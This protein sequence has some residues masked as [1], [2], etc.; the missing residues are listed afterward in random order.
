MA[1]VMAWRYKS[2]GTVADDSCEGLAQ[3][4]M[5]ICVADGSCG[6]LAMQKVMKLWLMTVVKV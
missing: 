5:M 6:G 1:V 3:W 2:D 4:M